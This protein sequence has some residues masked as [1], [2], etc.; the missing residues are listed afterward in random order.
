MDIHVHGGRFGHVLLVDL[1]LDTDLPEVKEQT[2]R[3]T[4]DGAS[5][6]WSFHGILHSEY[7]AQQRGRS[8][9]Q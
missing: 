4:C 1:A 9:T 2:E 7:E 3:R 8:D 6:P 5:S